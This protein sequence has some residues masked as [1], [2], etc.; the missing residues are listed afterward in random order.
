MSVSAAP[1]TQTQD[2]I[3]SFFD[4]TA[5]VRNLAFLAFFV[6]VTVTLLHHPF[7]RPEVGDP[8]IYDY[9]AQSILRG[10][11]PYKDVVDIKGPLAAHLSALSMLAGKPVGLRDI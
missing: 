7:S 3:W 8:A 4:A 10:Q 2:K 11:I 5:S 6:G 9:I 1:F